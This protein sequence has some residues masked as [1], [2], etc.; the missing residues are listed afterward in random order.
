MEEPLKQIAVNAGLE[1]SVIV[2]NVKTQAK[3]GYGY[4]ALKDEYGDMI[5]FGIVD[6]TKVTRSA[7]E[8]A[9]SVA[10]MVLTTEALIADK[11]EPQNQQPGM[12]DAGM[13]GMY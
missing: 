13:G 3:V 1:G 4:N 6:P 11:K 7:L 10:S 2:Q 9:S 5:G 12:P 8:N